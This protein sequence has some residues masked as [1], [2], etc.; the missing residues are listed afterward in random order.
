MNIFLDYVTSAFQGI[1]QT[2]YHSHAV[3][4]GGESI[5]GENKFINAW[6]KSAQKKKNR[7]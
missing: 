5:C 3:L 6:E 1:K 4:K 7:A 2:A